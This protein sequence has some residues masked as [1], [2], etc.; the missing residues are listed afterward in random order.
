MARYW[1]RKPP[2]RAPCLEPGTIQEELNLTSRPRWSD[3]TFWLGA[4][5]DR[6]WDDGEYV[7][8]EKS[9]LRETHRTACSDA[10][11]YS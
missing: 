9:G 8:G 3:L 4:W 10:P 2:I 1:I 7:D 5:S 6:L 11:L